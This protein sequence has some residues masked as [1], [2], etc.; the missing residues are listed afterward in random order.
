MKSLRAAVLLC[1]TCLVVLGVA[2]P[3]ADAAAALATPAKPATLSTSTEA[4]SLSWKSVSGAAGYRVQYAISSAFTAPK[5]VKASRNAVD[6]TALKSGTTY[7]LRVAALNSSGDVVSKNSSALKASTRSSGYSKLAPRDLSVTKKSAT[8]V[9]L[10]WSTRGA[11]IR[12]R[13]AYATSAS[14]KKVVYQRETST[15]LTLSNLRPNTSYHLKVRVITSSG[16][17]LSSYSPAITATTSPLAAPKGLRVTASAKKALALNWTSVSGAERYRVQYAKSASMSGAKYVRFTGAAGEL[18]GLASGATYYLKVRAIT[19]S[20][21]NLSDYSP[22][23]KATTAT[24]SGATYLPPTGLNGTPTAPGKLTVRWTSRGA[25]LAYQV[26]YSTSSAMSS[27]ASAKTSGGSLTLSG[28]GN[29]IPYHLR[30]RVV[31]GAGTPLSAFSPTV[32]LTTRTDQAVDL[33]VASYNIKCTNCYSGLPNEGTWYQRRDSVVATVKGQRPDV[34]GFQEASQGWLKDGAGNPVSKSQFE[35]LLERL[36][37]PFKITNSSRNNCVKSTTPTNCVYQ[38]RGA[39]QGTR[40]VYNSSTLALI[41]QGSKKLSKVV[42]SD[43]DRYAAWAILEQKQTGR[44][45]LF[46]DTHLE[47]RSDAAGSRSYY[48]LRIAQTREALALIA[49]K[50]KNLP[51]YFVGDF[52]SS[53]WASPS[54]GPYDVMRAAGF[55][56]PLGNSYQS[57]SKTSGAIVGRRIR[58]NFSSYNNFETKARSFSYVN[59]TYIDYIW[60]SKGIEVPEWETVVNVDAAGNFVGRIPSDH[61]MLR[62]TTRLP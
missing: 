19:P 57:T 12:Y 31:S 26:Q 6:I 39:S 43:P 49:A 27:A 47:F 5:S 24:S 59:G 42:T 20:G 8:S 3:P 38:D 28:L 52:N 7:Y 62:A 54:N 23:I 22:A 44:Q 32:T 1:V 34:I 15:G 10:T 21:A 46:V 60:V 2:P 18:S 33:R 13:V 9:S 56:D 29:A 36:G 51:V 25:G 16:A 48:N 58:T 30:V 53:K 45:F 14:F 50:R 4:I 37:A 55:V 41:D 61:N 40:I 11:G 17:N 35:D